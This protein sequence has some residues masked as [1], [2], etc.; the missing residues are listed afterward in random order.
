MRGRLL[1]R[2]PG[3]YGLEVIVH[4]YDD[5]KIEITIPGEGKRMILPRHEV[6]L[7]N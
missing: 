7:D 4:E 2:E 5:C 3:L 6:E 1:V